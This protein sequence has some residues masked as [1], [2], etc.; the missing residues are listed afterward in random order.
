LYEGINILPAFY[1]PFKTDVTS[2][3]ICT[4]GE[5]RW[6]INMKSYS[7]FAPCIITIRADKI[8]QYEYVSDDFE[9]RFIVMSKRFTDGLFPLIQE[10]ISLFQSVDNDPYIPLSGEELLV[11]KTYYS[12]FRQILKMRHNPYRS[13]MVKHLT[14]TFF[15]MP[16]SQVH[17]KSETKNQMPWVL[18][19]ENFLEMAEKHYKN[20]TASRILCGQTVSDT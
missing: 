8:F 3:V 12:M 9:G 2:F 20:R 14:M 10:R 15:Y 17:N 7:T 4:K 6:K 18:L 5:T 1:Q 19:V 16:F 11:F 13:E